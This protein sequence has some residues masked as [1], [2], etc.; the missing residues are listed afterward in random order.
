MT[1][2]PVTDVPTPEEI[3]R[4]QL[5]GVAALCEREV[6]R[7]LR[8]WSQTILP[9]V[10]GAVLFIVVFGMALGGRIRSIDGVSYREFIVPGLVLMGVVTAAFANNATSLYQARSDGFIEDPVS[11]P[12]SPTQLALGYCN[13]RVD[14]LFDLGLSKATRE[15]RAPYYQE[16]SKILN[17]EMPR[18]Y[19]WYEVR[20]LAFNNRAVGPA[21]HFSQ[22]PNLIFD[23][24][25]YNAVELWEVT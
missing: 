21:E 25:V 23:V 4:A 6:V 18:G 14:E 9:Q 12:M 3:R 10:L 17:E 8:L 7:V 11:S 24:P 19:L 13:E 15:E 20:P 1:A 22:M 2:R 5:R 16:I